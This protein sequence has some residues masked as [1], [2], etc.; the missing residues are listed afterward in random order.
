MF[1]N[2]IIEKSNLNTHQKECAFFFW[3]KLNF[4]DIEYYLMVNYNKTLNTN[5]NLSN[6]KNNYW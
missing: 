3:K 4:F 1:Y 6:V 2:N 5:H